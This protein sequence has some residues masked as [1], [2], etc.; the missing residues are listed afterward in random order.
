MFET[1]AGLGAQ[2]LVTYTV[3][4]MAVFLGFDL[5]RRCA[6]A[7]Q[8]LGEE[9]G[10]A[11]RKTALALLLW[12][13]LALALTLVPALR[14][15][16]AA[17]PLLQPVLSLGAIAALSALSLLPSFR[18]AFDSLPLE[19][20]MS[21]NYWRAIFGMGLLAFYTGGV[22]PSAFALPTAF[23]DMLVT[24]VMVLQLAAAQRRGR[25]PRGPL[26]VWNTLGLLDLVNALFLLVTVL[27]PWATAR[28]LAVGNFALAAFA[29]PLF[30]AIHLHIYARLLR[31]S[32]ASRR[33]LSVPVENAV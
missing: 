4:A 26:L 3:A 19:E 14:S 31:E 9:A 11:R 20:V 12:L 30:I 32:V 28:G 13:A 25:V 33:A 27:R 8:S 15:A 16:A 2:Q 6:R 18:R 21:I 5:W 1:L 23:G 22:L 10:A 24:C 7:L 29:V 17:T